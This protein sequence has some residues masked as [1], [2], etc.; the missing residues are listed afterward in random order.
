MSVYVFIEHQTP[1]LM[2]LILFEY[3]SNVCSCAGRLGGV[4]A[5]AAPQ[6]MGES[7]KVHF[8]HYKHTHYTMPVLICFLSCACYVLFFRPP[9]KNKGHIIMDLCVPDGSVI[10]STFS[11][12]NLQPVPQLYRTLRKTSWGGMFPVGMGDDDAVSVLTRN[13][14]RPT[15][16]GLSAQSA[17]IA[18]VA[19]KIAQSDKRAGRE[20]HKPNVMEETT[21]TR[22]VRGSGVSKSEEID[23]EARGTGSS[24]RRTK[25]EGRKAFKGVSGEPD[26]DDALSAPLPLHSSY[27]RSKEFLEADR[28]EAQRSNKRLAISMLEEQKGRRMAKL[29]EA[30]RRRQEER[31]LKALEQGGADNGDVAGGNDPNATTSSG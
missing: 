4:R 9:L 17:A 19:A 24:S 16:S 30:F 26:G 5:L 14:R 3:L 10:R 1:Q 12:S 23:L 7:A 21:A 20:S 13:P 25:A 29:G 18:T 27:R 2:H 22:R 28:V 8:V 6:R 31:R 15:R 11:R